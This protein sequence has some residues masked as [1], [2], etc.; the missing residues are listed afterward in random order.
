MKQ[1]KILG[2]VLL[3][4]LILLG[5]MVAG[6]YKIAKDIYEMMFENKRL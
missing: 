3:L 2:I 4:P 6:V 5:F 1:I